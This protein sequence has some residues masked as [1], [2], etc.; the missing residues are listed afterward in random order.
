VQERGVEIP[1]HCREH[2]HRARFYLHDNRGNHTLAVVGDAMGDAHF[3]YYNAKSF[4]QY[5]DCPSSAGPDSTV[6][7]LTQT[8]CTP[9]GQVSDYSTSGRDE[10]AFHCYVEIEGDHHR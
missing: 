6:L 5:G 8:A 4:Q 10:Q 1:G 7:F 2:R 3:K 9:V